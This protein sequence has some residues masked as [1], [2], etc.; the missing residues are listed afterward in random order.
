MIKIYKSFLPNNNNS[1]NS[2]EDFIRKL[3][4]I[5]LEKDIKLVSFAIINLYPSI[6]TNEINQIILKKQ[7]R[8]IVIKKLKTH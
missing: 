8:I 5:K 1:L 2:I 6:D 4:D 3:K 7:K